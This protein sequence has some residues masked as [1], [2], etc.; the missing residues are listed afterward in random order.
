[1]KTKEELNDLKAEAESLNGKL[2]ELN[3]ADLGQVAGGAGSGSGTKYR[4]HD[5]LVS[6]GNSNFRY[7]VI[8]IGDVAMDGDQ[9]YVLD[10]QIYKHIFERST[11]RP[12]LSPDDIGRG[13]SDRWEWVHDNYYEK[14]ES[15]IDANYVRA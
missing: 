9:R 12:V 7:I 6:P 8:G 2:A 11:P 13:S 15:F 5:V 14:Y 10:C 1:M 4:L 3:E